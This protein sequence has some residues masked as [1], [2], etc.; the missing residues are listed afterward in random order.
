MGNSL[1][2]FQQFRIHQD[3]C[4]MKL[5]TDAILLGSLAKAENPTKILD[6]GTGTGVIALMLAQRFPDAQVTAVEIDPDAAEQAAENFSGSAFAG[7]LSLI[8]ARVQDFATKDKFDLIV[9]NPPYFADHLKSPDSKRNRAL[10]TDELSFEELVV[11]VSSLL[12][13]EGKFW[14]I[15]PPRQMRDLQILAENSGLR[16]GQRTQVRDTP[17]K[18]FYREICSFSQ[19]EE[20]CTEE[21]ITLK[22]ADRS[23]S[24]YYSS[25]LSGFL[26]GY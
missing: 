3:R 11:K 20:D 10:H 21:I 17:D 5:S 18:L 12:S 23:Y 9:S 24:T 1:F 22:N 6:I 7:R 16:L 14:A 15:L 4:A 26:L 19:H 25:L 8:Q 2:Q 13:R